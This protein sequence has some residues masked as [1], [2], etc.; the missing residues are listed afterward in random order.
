MRI[1]AVAFALLALAGTARA[2]APNEVCPKRGGMIRTVDMT[3]PSVDPAISVDPESYTRLV[4]DSLIDVLP[5]LTFRPGLAREMPEQ[6]DPKTYVFHL[7][8]GVTFHDGT[9]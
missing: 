6:V 3:L 1:P 7:R 5:D 4:Y 2:Q 8:E 9:K